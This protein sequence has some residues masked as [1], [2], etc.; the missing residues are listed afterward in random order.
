MCQQAWELDPTYAPAFAL[1]AET[2]VLDALVG[3]NPR[4][5]D[6]ALNAALRAVR[7][8]PEDARNHVALGSF[9]YIDSDHSAAIAELETAIQLN[10]SSAWAYHMLAT[11]LMNLG[12]SEEGI[13]HQHTA[14]ALSPRDQALGRFHAR[15]AQGHLYLKQHEE[16]VKWARSAIRLPCIQWPVYSFLVAALAHLGRTVESSRALDDLLAVRP[17]LTIGFVRDRLPNTDGESK[18]HHLDGLRKAGLPE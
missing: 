4:D 7:L 18:E 11:T 14:F 2:Y 6:E 17:G 5:R 12:R 1:F 13:L 15:L 8:D 10:P 16:T 3:H 9:Y